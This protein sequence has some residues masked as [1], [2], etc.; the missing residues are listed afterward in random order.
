M[1]KKRLSKIHILLPLLILLTISVVLGGWYLLPA[2][3][4]DIMVLNKSVTQATAGEDPILSYRKHYG[5]YWM[6]EHLRYRKASD[7]K[8]YNFRTDYYGSVRDEKGAVHDASMSRLDRTPDLLYLSETYAAGQE[9]PLAG[10]LCYEDIASASNAH[11]H[12]ATLIA[13]SDLFSTTTEESIRK[14][15]E[16]LFGVNYTG[17]AGRYIVDMK[18]LSDVPEWALGLHETQY[19][20]QWNYKGD[21]ILLVSEAGDLVIL[22]GGDFN[23]SMLTIS[24]SDEYKSEFKCRTQSFYNWFI[25]AT[26]EFGSQ[27]LAEFNLDLNESGK[28][29]FSRISDKTTFPA[30]VRT[31][32]GL[33]PT[34]FFSGDFSDYTGQKRF[35][36]FLYASKFYQIFSYDRLGDTTSFY[37]DFYYPMMQTILSKTEKNRDSVIQPL[38]NNHSAFRIADKR[39]E[40]K[41]NGE[42][43][44]F[45]IKGFNI[46]AV[47]PGSSQYG[48]TRDISIYRQFLS[49][50]SA[51]NGN[52]IRVYD[53][54]PPEFYR[55]L[56]EYNM[57]Y[58]DNAMYIMQSIVT[59]DNIADGDALAEAPQTELRRNMEYIIDAV[60]G[61]AVVPDVGSR[62]GGTY[63]QDVS[64]Y[65][66]GYIIETDT[67]A[68]TVAALKSS[69]PNY[70]YKGEYVSSVG[71]AAEGLAAMLCDY[72][73]RYQQKEYGF[74]SPAGVKGNA[75]LVPSLTW[76]PPGGATF[77]PDTLKA[78]DKAQGSF[79]VSYALHPGDEALAENKALYSGYRDDDGCLPYGGYVKAFLKSQTHH[80][81]LIDGVGISTSVNAFDQDISLYGLSENQQGET[82]VRM[83][84]AINHNGCLGGLISDY[85]DSWSACSNQMQAYTLPKNR[86]A[87]WQNRLDPAQNMGVTAMEPQP[88][89]KVDMNLQDTERMREMQI[90]H[91]AAY[92]YISIMF[93]GEIDYDKEQL[94]IGLDTY[95]RNNGEYLYDPAYFATS[96]SGIEYI[97]KFESKNTA[98]LYVVPDYNREK[99]RYASKESYKGRYD[100][101]CQLVYGSFAS[102]GN[103]FYQAGSTL[104]IRLPWNLLNFTDPS[105]LTVLNDTRSANQIAADT[106]G[107]KTTATDGIIFSLLIA[108]KKSKDSLYVFPVNKQSSGYKT[109]SWGTWTNPKYIFRQ[110]Q[111]CKLLSSF[112][113]AMS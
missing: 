25:I 24:V 92:L 104:H 68:G 70:V 110:K 16:S 109:I 20:R 112:F 17:W 61:N 101:V 42:W 55:A 93:D 35:S 53:L 85:N 71:G 94:I 6:L 43:K 41:Q 49:E 28:K 91:N 54:L 50:I 66:A 90:R 1:V 87:L 26:T 48:Y 58:P 97:I 83:L 80:P 52:C 105:K 106:F 9:N 21:G 74:V 76:S 13:E 65:L 63:I 102:S 82:L 56:Y 111:S 32:E 5:F 89:E 12:G 67:G 34:Y 113:E 46:N 7:G 51:M 38:K 107:I 27:T 69:N 33:S 23:N 84:R 108:D 86:N 36:R 75:A 11:I 29:K 57:K 73:Y 14:E 77:N 40:V 2:R 96:L 79:F 44:P 81:V 22:E 100:H 8:A 4:L 60:H 64:A 98:A 15:A 37:W 10:G 47:M 78:S 39:L 95:Q 88:A 99:G 3:S 30:V 19:G 45:T 31:Q 72:T 18:D 62:R 103:S 59:P